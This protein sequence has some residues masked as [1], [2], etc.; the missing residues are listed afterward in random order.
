MDNN[1]TCVKKSC[2]GC[3]LC[4]NKCP[5]E[6]IKLNEDIEGFLYPEVLS[7]K[8]KE[9]GVCKSIC[10]A[11]NKTEIDEENYRKKCYMGLSKDNQIY[12]NSASG[13]F[14]TILSK[15]IIES[16][17]GIV[18]GCNLD[19]TGKVRHIRVNKLEDLN[20][21]QDSKYVQSQI[22]EIFNS[23]KE[24]LKY[25]KVL[26]I[27][28]PCQVDA[29]K[30]S[31]NKNEI[32]NLYTIDL[33]CHGVPSPGFFRKYIQFLSS[34]Y[35]E[36]IKKYRFRNKV[37]FDKCGF[38]SRIDTENR[39]RMVF[40]DNDI[41]YRDFI[42]GKNYRLSCYECQYKNEIRVGDFTIGDVASWE[43]YYDFYPEKTSSLIIINNS[44]ADTIFNSMKNNILYR[45]ISFE[46]EKKLNIALSQK[47]RIPEEREKI[48]EKYNELEFYENEVLKEVKFKLKI[49][50][51]LKRIIPFKIRIKVK[52]L[53]RKMKKNE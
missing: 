32:N 17:N 5:Y 52:K 4:F 21:L 37:N 27:G 26:F 51:I 14:A 1:I 6:A 19:E 35:R 29:I 9:C 16:E 39:K 3:G 13:G 11:I 38:I 34:K 7:N 30:K 2:F 18:Y 15:Y 31:L 10:P 47:N 43:N 53:I 40:T 28:T 8:C 24:D 12:M 48:Y 45:E 20:K 23:L 44:K 22:F 33:I 50:N 41:Y 25:S 42:E 49:K 46:E 36:K